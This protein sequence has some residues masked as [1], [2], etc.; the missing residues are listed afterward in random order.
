MCSTDEKWTA[1]MQSS[2]VFVFLVKFSV[3][4]YLHFASNIMNVNI[5]DENRI[6]L[7]DTT[8][9]ILGAKFST[10]QMQVEEVTTSHRSRFNVTLRLD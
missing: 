8:C 5:K 7:H 3:D 4:F 1:A 2:P 9:T 6:Y 10:E